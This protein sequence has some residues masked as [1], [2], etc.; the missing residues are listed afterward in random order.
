MKKLGAASILFGLGLAIGFIPIL[1]ASFIMK[2]NLF[3]VCI[4]RMDKYWLERL[5]DLRTKQNVS[6]IED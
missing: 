4:T 1:I 5:D 2:E 3:N 6:N